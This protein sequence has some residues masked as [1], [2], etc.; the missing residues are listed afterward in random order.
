[1]CCCSTRA[2]TSTMG[3]LRPIML[4][5]WIRYLRP[6]RWSVANP[7]GIRHLQS[8]QLTPHFLSVGQAIRALF[9]ATEAFLQL[10]QFLVELI[11]A[12]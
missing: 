7:S 3:T 2:S 5:R 1:M 11:A 4:F 10:F 6:A 8:R 9:S 12:D